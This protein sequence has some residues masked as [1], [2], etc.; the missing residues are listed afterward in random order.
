MRAHRATV[1]LSP[2]TIA[3]GTRTSRQLLVVFHG[4]IGT[5]D[6]M[7]RRAREASSVPPPPIE[8]PPTATRVP[9]IRLAAGL[10]LT[11]QSTAAFSC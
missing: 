10:L 1:S 2:P 8:W 5:P 9:S 3:C 4:A 11:A 7:V 6:F